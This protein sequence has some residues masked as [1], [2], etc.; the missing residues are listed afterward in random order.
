MNFQ[1][2]TE[3][4]TWFIVFC[5]AAGFLYSFILYRKEKSFSESGKWVKRS[6]AVLRFLS[7]TIICI[8]LLSPLIRTIFRQ[9]EKPIIILLQDESE[10]VITIRD[11][12]N[13]KATYPKEIEALRQSLEDDFDVRL[14]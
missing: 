12:A 14:F 10:S 7:V 13:F 11:S 6:M 8:L 5:I 4:P 2:L 3:A 9:I 1:L